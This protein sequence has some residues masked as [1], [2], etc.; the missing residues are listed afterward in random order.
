M[1]SEPLRLNAVKRNQPPRAFI[2]RVELPASECM[3]PRMSQAAP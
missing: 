3:M 1:K 2:E